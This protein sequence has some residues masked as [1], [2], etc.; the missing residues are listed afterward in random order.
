MVGN[1]PFLCSRMRYKKLQPSSLFRGLLLLLWFV[2]NTHSQ[3][4]IIPKNGVFLHSF[5]QYAYLNGR[6]HTST[7]PYSLGDFPKAVADSLDSLQGFPKA[8]DKTLQWLV[9]KDFIERKQPESQVLINPLFDLGLSVG[10]G[11][12]AR[13]LTYT[14]AGGLD[15]KATLKNKIFFDLQGSLYQGK[16]PLYIQQ[17]IQKDSVIPGLGY[18]YGNASSAYT[19]NWSGL[20]SYKPVS[21]FTATIGNGKHFI[22]DGYR[23]LLLSYN[24]NNYNYL[25]LDVN[26]WKIRYWVLYT[27]MM[28]FRGSEGNP[29]KFASKFATLHYLDLLIGKR[30][31]FGIFES[32]VW[33]NKNQDGITRGFDIQYLNPFIFFRPVEYSLG[34]PDNVLLGAN[35]RFRFLKRQVFYMQ[36]LLD[37]FFLKEV[38]AWNG[39]WANKQGFQVGLK[40][41]D[42]AGVK[43]LFYQGEINYIRPYTYTHYQIQQNYAHFGQPLA[44]PLGA[45]FVEGMGKLAFQSGQHGIEGKLIYS[46]F[47]TD[48]GSV[49]FGGNLYKPYTSRPYE[50]GNKVGQGIRNNMMYVELNYSYLINR[51]WN[52]R[53]EINLAM[54]NNTNLIQSSKETYVGIGLKSGLPY[55][56]TD[57]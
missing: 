32:V 42:L 1:I 53:F 46:I 44:H 21:Y 43:G 57:Y 30:L 17:H 12:G 45:N 34:S 25:K 23:S 51:K 26:F 48:S 38:K 19:Y 55:R 41:Y 18:A 15:I 11:N 40:G 29:T 5:E 49:N 13:Q 52:F 47:G 8:W 36:I 2:Q 37:E 27:R 28:D 24:A 33:E 6:I 56:Y 4:F 7:L 3:G 35:I 22:G 9:N 50:Y 39:W 54:R 31:S 20:L 14:L 10:K 16:Y